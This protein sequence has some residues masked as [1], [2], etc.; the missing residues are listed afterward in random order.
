MTIVNLNLTHEE[1]L[2]I[3]S[4]ANKSNLNSVTHA[5]LLNIVYYA[6]TD[7]EKVREK[8]SRKR[9]VAPRKRKRKKF[10]KIQKKSLVA[11]IEGLPESLNETV[12][13][14]LIVHT[15]SL[16]SCLIFGGIVLYQYYN[17]TTHAPS[18]FISPALTLVTI[19]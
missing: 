8:S 12:I 2:T 7:Q 4:V 15:P 6:L 1:S 17:G 3:L 16:S 5:I 19:Y 14:K 9:K 10:K 11:L 13:V 18:K